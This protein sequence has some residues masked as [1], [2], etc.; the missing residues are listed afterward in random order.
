[1]AAGFTVERHKL[2]EFEQF[3]ADRVKR[4]GGGDRPLLCV[5]GALSV[6]GACGG[7]FRDAGAGG[8]F[9][10]ANPE[11]LFVITDARLS[12]VA[13]AGADHLRCTLTDDSG[14]RLQ[15]IA[16]RCVET[17]MGRALRDHAGAL[18]HFAG[19]VQRK[20]WRG[21]TTTQLVIEDAAPAMRDGER[22]QCA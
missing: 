12:Y 20:T 1:M 14:A 7:T 21:R 10:M 5:D 11:P 17:P 18:F 15:A 2:A 9:G 4:P 22:S 6:A 19:R 13:V 3:M 16:F 8:P